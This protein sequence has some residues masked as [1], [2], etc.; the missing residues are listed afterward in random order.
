M[1]KLKLKE[2]KTLI[3]IKPDGVKRGLVGVIIQEIEKR[4]LKIVGLQMVWPS[5]EQMARHYS[6]STENL[7]IMGEKTLATYQEYNLDPIA[8]IGTDD[9][10]K[11]GKMVHSWI[12]DFMSSGPIVKMVVQGIHAVAMMRKVVGS[13]LP[14]KADVGTIRGSYSVDSPILANSQKRGVRNLVHAS[15]SISEAEAEIA[16]WFKPEEI[17]EYKRA[18]EDIMF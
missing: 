16:L 7:K 13:T 12:V 14:S 3:L 10:V 8:E 18:E 11:I 6:D 1:A 2:E 15:G 4:G 5:K 9:P 17:H